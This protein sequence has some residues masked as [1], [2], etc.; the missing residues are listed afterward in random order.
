MKR[1]V[2]PREF[3]LGRYDRRV[4]RLASKRHPGKKP[5]PALPHSTLLGPLGQD[6]ILQ[7]ARLQRELQRR[8]R[9]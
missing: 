4:T 1:T 2:P 3:N 6:V 9:R 8:S 5:R 7:I